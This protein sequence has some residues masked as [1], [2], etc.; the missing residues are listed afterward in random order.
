[1]RRLLVLSLFSLAL[2]LELGL[3]GTA[4]ATFIVG[5]NPQHPT[6]QVD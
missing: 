4:S 1:M 5:R 3:P 2:G 6:L